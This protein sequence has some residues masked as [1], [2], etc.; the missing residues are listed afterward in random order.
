MDGTD[1]WSAVMGLPWVVDASVLDV[2]DS[3][4]LEAR[5]RLDAGTPPAGLVVIAG[6]QTA[7]RGRRGRTWD[8]VDGGNVAV[9]VATP[10]P[11]AVASVPL[12]AALALAATFDDLGLATSCK[13]PNDVRLVVEG[14]PRKCA[15]VLCDVVADNV[16]AATAVVIGIGI[17]LDWRGRGRAGTAVAWTS[18]A[19]VMGRDVDPADVV[20]PLL[21]H[22]GQRLDQLTLRSSDVVDDYRTVCDTLGQRVRVEGEQV[23]LV[24]RAVDLTADGHLVLDVDGREHVVVAGDVVHLHDA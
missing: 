3:T 8:D 24:G 12:A 15:G 19:E 21:T 10:L 9:S 7:G 18:L 1:L 13:W 16:G 22:L 2:V 6:R 4:N 14:R 11:A 23:E 20:V 5:R 17:D